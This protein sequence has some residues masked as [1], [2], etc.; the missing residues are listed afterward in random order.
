MPENPLFRDV[1]NEISA[2]LPKKGSGP[3]N[4]MNDLPYRDWMKFQKSFFR[5]R[6]WPTLLDE[7]VRFFT[8]ERWQDGSFSRTALIGF[9]SVPNLST[10]DRIVE[11]LSI[12]DAI[13]NLATKPSD[14]YDFIFVDGGW[15]NAGNHS[16]SR[17]LLDRLFSAIARA[18]RPGKY[19]GIV[20]DY[21]NDSVFPTPWAVAIQ[22]RDHLRLRDER[23]GLLGDN[24]G[25][26]YCLFF[27]KAL[28]RTL[29]PS[30]GI[31][32]IQIGTRPPTLPLWVMPKS[33]PRKA[34]EVFHPAKFPERLISEF[35]HLF[36]KDRDMVLDP[37][38]GTGSAL[39]AAVRDGR[40]AIGIELNPTFARIA[41][42]KLKAEQPPL[43]KEPTGATILN[44]DARQV[45]SL[46]P[47]ASVQYCI[48]SPPYWSMLTNEGSENQRSRRDKSLPTVYSDDG[49]DIGNISAYVEF[50]KTLTSIYD[51]AASVLAEGGH[52]T[53]IVKNVKREHV[54]Y[55][56][57][58][59]LV[60]HLARTGG[61]YE[62]VGTTLW[63]QDDV[64]IKPFAV[65]IY[66]VSNT[67][68]TYCLH[69]RRK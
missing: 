37:M 57:G 28:E 7:T 64:S 24:D 27:E 41:E 39:I 66:W 38:A 42:A 62:Y 16:Q 23:V 55:P 44:G 2:P 59:D 25:C 32:E 12:K 45:A 43:L 69:F 67:L 19:A 15:L 56:L 3:P 22:G 58:W 11:R 34:D 35:I 26:R 30:R 36:S 17:P 5:F 68:H 52:L 31:D 61:R 51:S 40:N 63:C 54:L 20:V 9:E 60:R 18:L 6:D 10:S 53:I 21:S 4:R 29:E 1:D 50:L 49:Q 47:L 13:E 33:P 46:I 65:G 8:K 14:T 48:T